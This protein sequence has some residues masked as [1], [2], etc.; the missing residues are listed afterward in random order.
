MSGRADSGREKLNVLRPVKEKKALLSMV[1]YVRSD[2]VGLSVFFTRSVGG[3]E[4]SPTVESLSLPI[5]VSS[6]TAAKMESTLA[7]MR[8]RSRTSVA[9]N[10]AVN[11]RAERES[12]GFM[13]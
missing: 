11:R 2:G 7:A 3:M 13:T 10:S 9:M 6:L 1:L 4:P 5:F 8:R 12:A